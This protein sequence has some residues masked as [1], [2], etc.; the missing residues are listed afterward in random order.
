MHGHMIVKVDYLLQ[1]EVCHFSF[2][3]AKMTRL[4]WKPFKD[5]YD[6]FRGW[7]VIVGRRNRY[8]GKFHNVILH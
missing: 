6:F 3:A 5:K 8:N 7:T 4:V 1:R 2:F